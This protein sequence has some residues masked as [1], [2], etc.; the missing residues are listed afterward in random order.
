[1]NEKAVKY[2]VALCLLLFSSLIAGAERMVSNYGVTSGLSNG[3]VMSIAQDTDGII[4]VATEEGLNRFDGKHFTS[5]TKENSG[6]S[7]NELNCVAQIESDSTR[8]ISPERRS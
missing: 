7:A 6:L 3:Y 8:V 1:M 4:W 2:T 5:F